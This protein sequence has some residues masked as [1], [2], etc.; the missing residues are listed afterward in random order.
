MKKLLSIIYQYYLIKEFTYSYLDALLTITFLISIHIFILQELVN[1]FLAKS[2][3]PIVLLHVDNFS[4]IFGLGILLF[5]FIFYRKKK[6]VE[7]KY[8]ISYLKTRIEKLVLYF[9]ILFIFL[10]LLQNI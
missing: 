5:L 8:S 6:L 9:G 2:K 1:F 10:I 7:K 3:P 4:P